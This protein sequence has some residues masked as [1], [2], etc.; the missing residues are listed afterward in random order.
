MDGRLVAIRAQA[1][2]PTS[3]QCRLRRAFA[4]RRERGD[5]S[6]SLCLCMSDVLFFGP[7]HA[8]LEARAHFDGSSLR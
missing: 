5:A 8:A 2:Q 3:A 4:A 1:P 6:I 7:E